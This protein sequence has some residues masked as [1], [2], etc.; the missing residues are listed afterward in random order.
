MYVDEDKKTWCISDYKS[1]NFL[2]QFDLIMNL[3]HFITPVLINFTSS[4]CI[5]IITARK[6]SNARDEYFLTTLRQ[7]FQQ[8]YHLIISSCLLVL[9]ALPRVIISLFNHCLK[10]I[11]HPQLALSSYFLS[12]GPSVLIFI[13][14]VLPSVKYRKTFKEIVD[15]FIFRRKQI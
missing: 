7:Q 9:L 15:R 3:I 2:K 11:K 4:S 12:F 10:S 14:F 5:I 6:R 1:R 8:H 13:I